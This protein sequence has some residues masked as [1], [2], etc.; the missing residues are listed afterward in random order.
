MCIVELIKFTTVHFIKVFCH[1]IIILHN[2]NAE[3]E[4]SL[5]LLAVRSSRKHQNSYSYWEYLTFAVGS[6]VLMYY[7]MPIVRM[8]I[9]M[10]GA[11][12]RSRYST[13]E[14]LNSTT[15]YHLFYPNR[16]II[17][18]RLEIF[19]V[20]GKRYIICLNHE[21]LSMLFRPLVLY[22]NGMN[23]SIILLHDCTV[24]YAL[25]MQLG[26]HNGELELK[27]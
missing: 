1:Y 8:H 19:K 26:S 20:E 21:I 23:I 6:N 7:T 17:D 18:F 16:M 4:Y 3:V 22:L 12:T 2:S 10:K 13:F 27:Y 24:Q 14:P 15:F 11:W 9:K 5:I 25:L